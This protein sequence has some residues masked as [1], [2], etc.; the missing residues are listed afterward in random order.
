M[1]IE[2][3]QPKTPTGFMEMGVKEKLLEIQVLI[4][5]LNIMFR[6][7]R[8]QYEREGHTKSDNGLSGD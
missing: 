8:E 6:E 5:T 4:T 7:T 2:L 3:N 1:K